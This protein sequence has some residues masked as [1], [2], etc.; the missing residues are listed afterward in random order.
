VRCMLLVQGNHLEADVGMDMDHILEQGHVV[1][2]K[3]KPCSHIQ[4]YVSVCLPCT[5][6]VLRYTQDIECILAK[7]DPYVPSVVKDL[8]DMGEYTN[9]LGSYGVTAYHCWNYMAPQ[10]RD[11][12]ATWTVAYQLYK[13]GCSPEEFS[14]SFSTWGHYLETVENC[15]W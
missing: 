8:K 2:R 9:S 3:F 6:H 12:D 10:H 1:L 15:V 11:V 5:S 7:I 13:I 4:R 14:F